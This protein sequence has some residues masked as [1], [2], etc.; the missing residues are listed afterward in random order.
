[1]DENVSDKRV[2]RRLAAVLAADMV[3]YSRLMEADE[4]GTIARQREH[5]EQLIDPT[6][7]RFAGRIV[8]TS[9]DGMLVEFASAVD[10][11]ECA[12]AVQRA[13]AAR[14]AGR[15]A[16]EMIRYRIGI[17]V[18]DIVIDGD[19]ILGDGVN[20]AA[21]LEGLTEAGGIAISGAVHEQVAGK[22]D[23]TFED[24]GRHEVKNITRPLQV[25]RWSMVGGA[26]AASAPPA[27]SAEPPLAALLAAIEVPSLAVL[28]FQNMSRDPDFDYF[29]D[30]LTESL[31]TDL[32]RDS[33]LTVASRNSSFELKGQALNARAAAERLDVRYLIEGSVQ[34]MGPRMRINAQLIEAHT[35]EHLWADRYDRATDDLFAVQDALCEA[36]AVEIDASI[37]A[38]HGR[39][40]RE[41][42]AQDPEVRRLIRQSLIYLGRF[43]PI[44]LLK[45]QQVSDRAMELEPDSPIALLMASA[46][47][48]VRHLN[49]WTSEDGALD[50]A[51]ALAERLFELGPSGTPYGHFSRAYVR[52]A[53]GDY[54]GGLKDAA[55]AI[56]LLEGT[57]SIRTIHARILCAVGRFGEARG[58]TIQAL[59]LH[60]YPYPVILI[61]LGLSS[62][63]DERI[64]D[65]VAALEKYRSFEVQQKRDDALLAAALTAADRRDEAR[66][67]IADVMAENPTLTTDDFVR[68]YPFR[69][70]AHREQL[71]AYLVEAGL[72]R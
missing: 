21:R 59:K 71:A 41:E 15:T 67:V 32:S 24:G 53:T 19:D 12:V 30:G 69:D 72:P 48:T 37:S 51:L 8:K 55:Q 70:P 44:S 25:W 52:L 63:M 14:E 50:T 47:R 58:E 10:A 6:V 61:M 35:D 56:A 40:A 5:R 66:A 33:R 27:A 36:I 13:M 9:G 22:L 29:C 46:V 49:S 43:D 23:V 64:E 65:A 57:S 68:P 54:D 18:G 45:C 26:P 42:S 7:A 38:G 17:N 1:M 11:V 60:P 2:E 4:A 28:P 20:L 39:H 3:G 31:I 62:L 34:V 16:G